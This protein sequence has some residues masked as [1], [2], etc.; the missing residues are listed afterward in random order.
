MN[1]SLD[2]QAIKPLKARSRCL[3]SPLTDGL[4]LGGAS[5]VVFVA[6]RIANV[7]A[8]G[9]VI[10][11]G[12]ML[13][14]ANLVNHPHFAHSYQLFYGLRPL[15]SSPDVPR[16]YRRRWVFTAYLIPAV[17]I[18]LLAIGILQWHRGDGKWLGGLVNLMAALVGWHYVKQ[19]FGMIMLDA[20]I[21]HRFWP[22]HTRRVLLINAY[23]CWIAAWTLANTGAVGA[24]FWGIFQVQIKVPAYVTVTFCSIV[25]VTTVWSLQ[26]VVRSILEWRSAGF[27]WN[28]LPLNGALAYLIALYLWT[29]F[30]LADPTYV[31]VIPF[32]H[33]LQYLAVVWRYKLNETK[34]KSKKEKGFSGFL[35]TG[36]VMG[37]IGF[38][39]LPVSVDYLFSRKLPFQSEGVFVAVATAWLFINIHHYFIDGVIWRRENPS[40]KRYL[41]I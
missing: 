40:L 41:Y 36:I 39:I 34:E 30:S 29:L 32:F 20:A 19:G 25:A 5:V 23:C 8:T 12:W 14:L 38:W 26:H 16:S 2:I 6:I 7:D 17:I 35:A 3:Y 13:I 21:K 37:A 33:S 1:S 22:P 28:E 18:S 10:L 15:L 4:L 11:A 9:A 27:M 24:A 31:L